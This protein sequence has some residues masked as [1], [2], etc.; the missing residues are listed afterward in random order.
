[1][2]R[3]LFIYI[4]RFVFLVF[5]QVMI[6]N[7]FEFLNVVTPF[8][9]VMFIMLLPFEASPFVAVILGFFMGLSI[10]FF[11]NTGG[12]HAAALTLSA[13]SR[14]WIL[15]IIAPRNN[16]D[17]GS[18][19]TIYYYGIGWFLKYAFLYVLIHYT[20]YFTLEILLVTD[21]NFIMSLGKILLNV[22][23]TVLFLLLSQMFIRKN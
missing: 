7:N 19:P 14:Q 2:N 1:M 4:I 16:Y 3:E 23:F 18:V 20:F 8:V 11:G 12:L 15:R 10:D 21:E 5:F 22:I 6:L 9:Y 17:I 13:Y